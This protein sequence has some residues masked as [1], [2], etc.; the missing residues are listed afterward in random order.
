MHVDP[1][2]FQWWT[3]QKVKNV[4]LNWAQ[5]RQAFKVKFDVGNKL[6]LLS[7]MYNRKKSQFEQINDFV[8]EKL[9][10]IY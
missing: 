2:T 9:I 8:I 10:N 6:K 4:N 1:K 5:L 7:K 3:L